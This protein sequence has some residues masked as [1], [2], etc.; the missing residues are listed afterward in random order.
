MRPFV[1]PRKAALVGLGPA[2]RRVL[3]EL[4]CE[5]TASGLRIAGLFGASEALAGERLASLTVLPLRSLPQEAARLRVKVLLRD[6]SAE[7]DPAEVLEILARVGPEVQIRPLLAAYQ[8]ETGKV[9]LD[10]PGK[11]PYC[12]PTATTYAVPGAC[13]WDAW[14]RALDLTGAALGLGLSIPVLIPLVLVLARVQGRPVFFLQERLGKDERPFRVIKLR[15]MVPAA[16]KL[17]GETWAEENDPRVTRL[18]RLLRRFRLDELPQLVNVLAGDM[19]LVGPR[20]E[21]PS[22]AHTLK[23]KLPFYALRFAV[24]P[25]MTGWAQ[26]NFRYGASEADALEKLRYE[27]YYLSNRSLRLYL[28]VLARTLPAILKNPGR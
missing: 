4:G 3:A 7:A 28:R 16:E 1:S 9:P 23:E 18:G 21:R 19:S 20:P 12:K 25:G 8:E 24:K 10:L 14:Q 27:L 6:E 22:F 11:A 2:A 5:W 17:T 26:V 13:G 15:T